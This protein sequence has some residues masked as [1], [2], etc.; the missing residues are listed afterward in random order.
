VDGEHTAPAL[1]DA[2]DE[3]VQTFFVCGREFE[4]ARRRAR[5]ALDTDPRFHRHRNRDARL[6]G[7]HAL[8]DQLWLGHQTGA[9]R[10]A[11]HAVA[12]ASDVEV[13]LVIALLATHV[14]RARELLRI[15]PAEL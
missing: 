13:D 1:R 5:T 8:G 7:A 12:R 2:R 6:H 11:L 4:P 3:V 14:R 15:A 10:T 9:E